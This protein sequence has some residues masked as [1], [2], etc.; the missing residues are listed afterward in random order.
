MGATKRVAR[1]AQGEVIGVEAVDGHHEATEEAQG[2]MK[3]A[4]SGDDD[5][6]LGFTM[7][8]SEAGEV[9]AAVQIAML[10]NLCYPTLRDAVIAHPT[11]VEGLEP[12]L[13][14]VPSRSNDG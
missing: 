10:A 6:I 11:I 13:T 7:I 1:D 12:L 3:V 4:V 5:R 14:N 8:G 9:V 2:F